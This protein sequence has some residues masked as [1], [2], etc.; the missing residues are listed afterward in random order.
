MARSLRHWSRRQTGYTDKLQIVARR[1][2]F[3]KA[4]RVTANRRDRFA[5][6][7]RRDSGKYFGAILSYGDGVFDMS[8][9]PPVEGNYRLAIRQYLG[10]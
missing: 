8:T 3:A 5:D 1:F 7:R 6:H 10:V 9:G 2:R 4:S